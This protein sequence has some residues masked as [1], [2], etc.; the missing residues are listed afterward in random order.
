MAY[1]AE[2][3]YRESSQKEISNES[4][5]EKNAFA[6]SILVSIN[7]KIE[8]VTLHIV[9]NDD[10]HLKS[11][12][13]TPENKFIVAKK[14]WYPEWHLYIDGKENKVYKTNMIHMGFYLPKGKHTVEFI[15][16]P[17][18]FYV[19]CAVSLCGAIATALTLAFKKRLN[20]F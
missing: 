12:I 7:Q 15:Y 3:R 2:K 6:E 9:K 14:G 13:Y 19:G 16:I 10:Q 8:G 20:Q 11:L 4:I 1:L 17:T 18:S 5:S